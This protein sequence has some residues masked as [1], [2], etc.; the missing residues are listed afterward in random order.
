MFIYH[1]LKIFELSWLD[2]SGKPQFQPATFSL[3]SALKD[4]VKINTFAIK[5]C[6]EA[7]NFASFSNQQAV[8]NHLISQTPSFLTGSFADPIWHIHKKPEDSDFFDIKQKSGVFIRKLCPVSLQ[9]DIGFISFQSS[10]QSMIPKALVSLEAL[11]DRLYNTPIANDHLLIQAATLFQDP[12]CCVGIHMARRG[13][14]SY[15]A[16]TYSREHRPLLASFIF[17]S[18]IE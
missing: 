3:E 12:S 10:D 18:S 6:C 16:I 17:R 15:S 5:E 8:K 7:L 2:P 14:I 1:L 11:A 13:G 9:P 4:P